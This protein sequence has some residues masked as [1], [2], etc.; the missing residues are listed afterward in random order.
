MDLVPEVRRELI[1]FLTS[2]LDCFAWCYDDMTGISP[3]V[4][5][6]Q[7]NVD[8]TFKP[9][10][11]KRRKFAPERNRIVNEEVQKLLKIGSIR[12]VKYPDW[13]ANVVVVPKKNGKHRVC[14]DFTDLN[15]ACPKD[16][17]PLPHIDSLVDATS[18][19]ELL[20]FM[21]A[22]SGYNQILM[23]PND[24]EKT[25]FITDRG[26]YCYKVMPFGLK[27]AGATYQRLVNRMFAAQLGKTMKVYIDDMLV[28]SLKAEDHINHL[29]QTFDLLRKYNM[30]LNP[31]KCTFGVQSG[32]FLGYL[33]SKRGIEANPSQ[34]K[35][36]LDI[37]SPKCVKDVQRLTGKIA[38]LTR[39]ISKSS[40]RCQPFFDILKKNKEFVWND[41]AEK[42]LQDLKE[43]LT[44]P[45][46]LSKPSPGETL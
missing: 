31:E 17:F 4:I 1:S 41:A 33:V 25:S 37:P 7:L 15:K 26:T 36:V 11:Q 21:D 13:L 29:Q 14:I 22:F 19:H 28:K 24:Q 12:E 5:E 39:F 10:R 45:P 42:A 8:P 38:A 35:A 16:S 27:N 34:I 23:H 3:D 46:L 2:N 9:V 44:S 20:S 43:Y 32:K 6:H 18:G 30:K 40:E